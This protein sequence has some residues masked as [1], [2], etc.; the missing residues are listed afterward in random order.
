VPLT[1]AVKLLDHIDQLGDDPSTVDV[2]TREIAIFTE[3][4]LLALGRILA[5]RCNLTGKRESMHRDAY[6]LE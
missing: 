2:F 4:E 5:Q 1:R 3:A 6:R